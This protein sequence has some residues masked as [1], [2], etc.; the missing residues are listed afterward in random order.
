MGFIAD[1]S[2]GVRPLS[3][4]SAWREVFGGTAVSK[5][6]GKPNVQNATR[7]GRSLTASDV[8]M[9]RLLQAYRSKTP[10][11][12]SDDRSEQS[13]HF[14]GIAYVA[15][16]RCC[17]QLAQA[18]PRVM[19]KDHR[20]PDGKRPVQ[21]GEEGY[22]LV[23]LLERPNHDDSFGDLIYNW[24]MQLD[25]T[26]MALTWMVPNVLG[27]PME[28]Y[29][30]P[31]ATAQSGPIMTAEYPDGYWQ[32]MPIYPNGPFSQYPTPLTAAGARIDSKWMLRM[33]YPHPFLRYDGYSPMTA[34]RHHLD[35]IESIDRS[36]FYSMKRSVNPSAVLNMDDMEGMV[37]LP[38]EEIERIRAD[39]EAAQ[40]GPENAGQLFVSFPGAKLE[41]WGSRP[42][43]MEYQHGWDQLSSFCLGGFGITKQAAG[44]IEDS[45]Y[46]TLYA[47]LK[48]L[49]WTTLEPKCARISSQLTHHLAPHFGDGLSVEVTCKRIDDHDVKNGK[50]TMLMSAK[51][52][53]KNEMR[54]EQGFPLTQE[55]WG[56]EIA[57]QESLV[58]IGVDP[59]TGLPV[60]AEMAAAG[61]LPP[62]DEDGVATE[63]EEAEGLIDQGEPDDML[64]LVP[65]EISR[66]RPQ[67]GV[68][69]RGA[70][71]ERKVKSF[72]EVI[73]EEI[74]NGNGH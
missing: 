37:P 12:W 57:G 34:L 35:Q 69:G 62:P 15:I 28:L 45:S 50:L 55:P 65:S 44:M 49:Y 70:M 19:R 72:Y 27:V 20:H 18:V 64:N 22:D 1:V 48:Q 16:H 29:P 42:V 38:E 47:T 13:R 14:V 26:G 8:A 52:I 59:L 10:G 53:T 58:P 61:T 5:E 46:S 54:H 60:V 25:L 11:G 33:K 66:S 56:V 68:M 41:Q 71:G 63:A 2:K 21:K 43:D 39:F 51:A 74:R 40:Q 3:G 24:G 30:I 6:D 7:S 17:E 67:P 32:I 23:E 9:R 73:Q 36:R 4:V 31:T